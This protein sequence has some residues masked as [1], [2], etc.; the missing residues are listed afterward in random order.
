MD[1]KGG[2]AGNAAPPG[3]NA[4]ART[5]NALASINTPAVG[6]AEIVFIH[7]YRPAGAPAAICQP[8][9]SKREGGREGG[10]A[11]PLCRPWAG[12]RACAARQ[13]RPPPVRPAC[14]SPSTDG[15]S[16][17]RVRLVCGEHRHDHAL[18]HIDGAGGN[19]YR[20]VGV[21]GGWLAQ[22]GGARRAAANAASCSRA[23]LG[24]HAALP[25]SPPPPTAQPT[26]LQT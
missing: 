15:C 21:C 6:E 3:L 17:C 23:C 22:S 4:G 14:P 9:A 24:P 8:A 20:W 16:R 7:H 1:A 2:V 18:L 25:C 26:P 5:A 13:L 11:A 12:Q 10:S 19:I